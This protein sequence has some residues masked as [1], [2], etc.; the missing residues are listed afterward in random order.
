MTSVLLSHFVER[1]SFDTCL[2]R[3]SNSTTISPDACPRICHAARRERR[4]LFHEEATKPKVLSRTAIC[5]NT[6]MNAPGTTSSFA[7]ILDGVLRAHH[8]YKL[9]RHI[10]RW[11]TPS[12]TSRENDNGR[13]HQSRRK[14]AT[15]RAAM[16][17]VI[18]FAARKLP[19]RR[20]RRARFH[21]RFTISR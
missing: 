21:T 8:G 10:S 6:A 19:A 18:V 13:A 9:S 3:W 15:A 20:P 11:V 14:A 12:V 5:G 2:S 17:S 4:G 7:C 1:A 16:F